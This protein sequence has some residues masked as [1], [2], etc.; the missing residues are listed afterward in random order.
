[1][2]LKQLSTPFLIAAATPC[3]EIMASLLAAV[4][5][6]RKGT[7]AFGADGC[8]VVSPEILNGALVVSQIFL[9]GNQQD[10]E[11]TAEVLNLGE[12]LH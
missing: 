7:Y 1:M 12:P 3:R 4:A 6:R 5:K 9:A 11:A 2:P 8:L 10:G